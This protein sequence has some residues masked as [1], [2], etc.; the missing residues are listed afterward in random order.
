MKTRVRMAL[1]ASAKGIVQTDVTVDCELEEGDT[2]SE[3]S[4]LLEETVKK[5]EEKVKTLGYKVVEVSE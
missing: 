1:K 2:T 3:V 4:N 5:Y